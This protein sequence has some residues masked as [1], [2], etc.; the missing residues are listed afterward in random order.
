MCVPTIVEDCFGISVISVS[1][2]DEHNFALDGQSK[3]YLTINVNSINTKFKSF[4]E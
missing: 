4:G 3:Q 2:A 1:S